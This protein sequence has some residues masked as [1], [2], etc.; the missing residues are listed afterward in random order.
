M[1]ATVF[2]LRFFKS[3]NSA[4]FSGFAT[5][6]WPMDICP[7]KIVIGLPLDIYTIGAELP[8]APTSSLPLA[9]AVMPSPELLNNT[10]S[11]FNPSSAK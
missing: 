6:A 10:N 7:A 11:E 3:A 2:P 5:R 8:K 9:T 4:A 1:V